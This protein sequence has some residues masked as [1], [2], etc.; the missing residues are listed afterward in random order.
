MSQSQ[1]T[2]Y[3]DNAKF[4]LMILVVFSHL[5]Q[6][7]IGDQKFYH[8]LYYF[9][10]TFHMP[11]FVFLAGYFAKPLTKGHKLREL[12]KKFLLPYVF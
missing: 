6:P 1:R 3:F 7:F 12:M 8:D 2:A 9:I 10:F 5:L 4:L 11:A